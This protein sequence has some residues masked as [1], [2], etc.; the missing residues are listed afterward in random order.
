MIQQLIHSDD[1][2]EEAMAATT[3]DSGTGGGGGSSVRTPKAG[4]KALPSRKGGSGGDA[5]ADDGQH[6]VVSGVTMNTST[7]LTASQMGTIH[8]SPRAKSSSMF[9]KPTQL[10]T[11]TVWD[12]I[13][14]PVR[15][16]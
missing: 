12:V 14:P 5:G 10:Q 2:N 3:S 6:S 16:L 8:R 4:K 11:A 15:I 7:T 13:S 9:Q 1:L